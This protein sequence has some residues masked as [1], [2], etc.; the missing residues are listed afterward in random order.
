L[1]IFSFVESVEE[2]FELFDGQVRVLVDA[3]R[4]RVHSFGGFLIVLIDE[5]KV[6]LPGRTAS[7]L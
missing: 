2:I 1:K 4:E 3:D 7:G 6:L 5:G